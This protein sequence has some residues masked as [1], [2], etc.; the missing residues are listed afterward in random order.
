ML[1]APSLGYF[2]ELS[3]LSKHTLSAF[4]SFLYLEAKKPSPEAERLRKEDRRQEGWRG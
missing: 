2:S 4:S 1:R 3:E